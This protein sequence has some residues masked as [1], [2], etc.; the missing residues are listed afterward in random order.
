MHV[1]EVGVSGVKC[2]VNGDV[3]QRLP[4]I[5]ISI[6]IITQR[7]ILSSENNAKYI[8]HVNA[9][10]SCLL[11]DSPHFISEWQLSIDMRQIYMRQCIY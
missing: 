6:I 3:N 2:I 1:W 5:I 8:C 9:S 4:P 10:S 11:W 7:K